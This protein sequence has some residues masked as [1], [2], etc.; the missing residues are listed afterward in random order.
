[1]EDNND[2]DNWR[3]EKEKDANRKFGVRIIPASEIQILQMDYKYKLAKYRILG[4]TAIIITALIV[5]GVLL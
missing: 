5:A 3:R 1:M 4:L 2:I